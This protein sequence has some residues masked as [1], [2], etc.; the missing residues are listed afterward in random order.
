MAEY[1]LPKYLW[2]YL[3]GAINYT[4]N[5]LYA[6][7]I[8]MSPYEALYGRK[9]D[10]SNLRALGCQCW[11]HMRPQESGSCAAPQ[12]RKWKEC[13]SKRGNVPK[14]GSKAHAKLLMADMA[15]APLCVQAT[16]DN[17]RYQS[18]AD[19]RPQEAETSRH[20]MCPRKQHSITTRA[21]K[22]GAPLYIDPP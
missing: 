21:Q 17:E 8:E 9:P 20:G 19:N 10:P 15:E 18:L 1:R 22:R 5:R 12:S 13:E 4:I 7:K 3:L 14:P 11:S 2:G 6:S 16:D